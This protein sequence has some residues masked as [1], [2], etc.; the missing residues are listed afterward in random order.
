MRA[1][2]LVVTGLGVGA[3]VVAV[4]VSWRWRRIPLIADRPDRAGWRAALADATATLGAVVG[5]G[6]LAGLLVLGLGG[7]LVMRLLAATSG[8]TAQGRLTEAGERVGEIT[9]DGTIGFLLFV[10]VGGGV[11]TAIAFLLVRRWLPSTAGPAGLVA[12]LLLIGTLGVSDPFSPDNVDFAILRPTWLAIVAVT[13][14]GLLFATTY[15]A[16]AARLDHLAAGRR[17]LRWL[18]CASLVLLLLPPFALVAIAYVGGR[19]AAQ[20]RVR[21]VLVGRRPT[22]AGRLLVGAATLVAVC[23]TAAATVRIATA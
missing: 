12:G 11:L 7:R 20:G 15:T 19:V 4:C 3:L 22:R 23:V 5:A 6:V 13:V 9:T 1:G 14:T 16:V 10:G 18:P 8:R 2:N 21:A 17:R